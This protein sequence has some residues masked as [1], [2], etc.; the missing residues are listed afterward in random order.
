[1]YVK[2]WITTVPTQSFYFIIPGTI[3]S[4]AFILNLSLIMMHDAFIAWLRLWIYGYKDH[5]SLKH[6]YFCFTTGLLCVPTVKT[7]ILS[8]HMMTTTISDIFTTL[9]AIPIIFLERWYC[10]VSWEIEMFPQSMHVHFH[11]MCLGNSATHTVAS[12]TGKDESQ[13][14]LEKS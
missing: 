13:M 12:F 1:M 5:Y 4:Q 9:W 3:N 6:Y 7:C 14:F 11:T 10:R 8:T 2:D